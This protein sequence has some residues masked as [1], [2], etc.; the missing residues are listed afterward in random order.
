MSSNEMSKEELTRK[1][2]ELAEKK[3]SYEKNYIEL[4]QK[5]L[6]V[7]NAYRKQ[8]KDTLE[9]ARSLLMEYL[10]PNKS[11]L[12][13]VLETDEYVLNIKINKNTSP[14]TL[15][16]QG[17]KEI[18]GSVDATARTPFGKPV[19]P[20]SEEEI[21]LFMTAVPDCSI[22]IPSCKQCLV[23][24]LEAE[25]ILQKKQFEHQENIK[26]KLQVFYAKEGKTNE[27]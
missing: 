20:F 1:L 4:K 26:N 6:T 21:V 22:I 24:Y 7:I 10:P 19:Y 12:P 17:E 11:I 27:I 15:H 13:L 14:A 9:E 23:A 2:Q 3:D 25:V 5:N 18:F 16:L 8:L